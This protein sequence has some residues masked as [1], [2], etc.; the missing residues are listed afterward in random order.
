V[1][2]GRI[3]V[4]PAR[5]PAILRWT[6]LLFVFSTVF[7]S[8]AIEFFGPS[9]TLSRILGISLL[10][11]FMATA[12]TFPEKLRWLG[13]DLKWFVAFFLITA[14]EELYRALVTAN[15]RYELIAY[16]T[17][18]QL[19]V[20]FLI[21]RDVTRDPR[22]Y[23]GVLG[24]FLL[25]YIPGAVLTVFNLSL[26]TEAGQ[27]EGRLGLAGINLNMLAFVYSV[28]AVCIVTWL[29]ATTRPFSK[30]G[31]AAIAAAGFLVI[32]IG[33]TGS[34][35]GAIALVIG[36]LI[37]TML[38]VRAKRIPAYLLLVPI[39][40]GGTAYFL[41]TEEVLVS[42]LN[43]TL[44]AGDTGARG[45][46]VESGIRLALERPL[47]GF[48]TTYGME[49][50]RAVGYDY[51]IAAH[52]IYLQIFLS[53]GMIGFVPFFVGL[54]SVVGVVWRLRDSVWG[55]M[56][57]AVLMMT[58]VFGV[59]GHFAD[60]KYFWIMIALAANAGVMVQSTPSWAT[61]QGNMRRIS[62][63]GRELSV[64]SAYRIGSM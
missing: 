33:R 43:A 61:M 56:W 48:G 30:R 11:V 20:M 38:N 34:R 51:L 59:V 44:S 31:I 62:R 14:A 36:L 53:F 50:S 25:T 8:F 42:R 63:R 13:K 24:V 23:K 40:V 39:I 2:K 21:F 18:V 45:E 9:D 17:Y 12:L 28:I 41:G 46:I 6:L 64:P 52:N 4:K 22:A 7:D 60:A 10:L 16:F 15:I 54:A 1:N 35:G 37:T 5:R 29:F 19:F 32:A 27:E 26:V 47:I 49:L 58:L 3:A 55:S 57:L